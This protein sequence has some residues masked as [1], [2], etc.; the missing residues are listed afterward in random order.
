MVKRL[1]SPSGKWK[2]TTQTGVRYREHPT[3]KHGTKPDRYYQVR[4]KAA[5]K[6]ITE[7][8]GWA[9][10]GWTLKKVAEVMTEMKHE[11]KSGTGS[12]K[13]ADRRKAR[14]ERKEK[15]RRERAV[16]EQLATSYENYFNEQ[17][18]PDVSLDKKSAT[19]KA[20]LS[21]HRNWILPAIGTVPIRSIGELQ[22]KKVSRKMSR[23]DKA[24]RSIEYALA[25]IRMVIGHAIRSGY[26]PGPNPV[27]TL[28]RGSRPKY[29][30]KRV[31]F[32]SREEAS[33][34]LEALRARSIAVHNM[35]LLS[36]YCGLRAGEIFSLT[37]GDVD[38]VHG[39]VTLRNTKSGKTRTLNMPPSVRRMFESMTPGKK[40]D[41]VFPDKNGVKRKK[42]SK[43]FDRVV[44][45]LGFNE[46]IADRRQRFTFHN[47]RHTCASWLVQAGIPLFTVKEIMGHSTIALTERYSHLAPNA[48]QQAAEAIEQAGTVEEIPSKTVN[49]R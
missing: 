44:K 28:P 21:L 11:L 39:L 40:S 3:R 26:H 46:G 32:L 2:K 41:Y 48:F 12:G 49:L 20:E 43:T 42:M 22:I 34:L 30:N 29:D 37:W 14:S 7:C 18:W 24:P 4:F 9:S 36:L 1:K 15:K 35:T 5:G 16:Q 10:E 47:C 25:C 33:K 17:Y 8:Y 45:A 31:R 13:L 27:T 38:L 23:A 6:Q 19:L